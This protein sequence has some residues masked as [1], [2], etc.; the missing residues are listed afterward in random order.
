MLRV[1][2]MIEDGGH[3]MFLINNLWLWSDRAEESAVINKR[4]S[5][6]K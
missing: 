5:P 4:P 1:R 2:S 3:L 6:M